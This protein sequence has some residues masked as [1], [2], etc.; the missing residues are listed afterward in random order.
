MLDTNIC[1]FTIKNRPQ[2]VRAAFKRHHGQM[3]ISTV[4]LMELIYGAEKS[5]RGCL[6]CTLLAFVAHRISHAL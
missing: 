3:C 1:I 5:S 6:C 2:E 4:T